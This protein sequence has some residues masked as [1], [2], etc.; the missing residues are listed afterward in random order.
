MRIVR[1]LF[2]M[3]PIVLLSPCGCN[4]FR[5][6]WWNVPK[7]DRSVPVDES[8]GEADEGLLD[9]VEKEFR[10]QPTTASQPSTAPGDRKQ[11][12]KPPPKRVTAKPSGHLARLD[13]SV[14]TPILVIND[15]VITIEE[16]LD[17]MRKELEE[18][19]Q[20]VSLRQYRETINDRARRR[21]VL[22]IDEI[23]VYGEA[24][25]EISDEMEPAIVKAIDDTERNR[26]NQEFDGRASRY[27]A[28]IDAHGLKRKEI[29]RRIR[30][31]LVV[32]QYL[33]DKFLPLVQRPNRGELQRYYAKHPDE[34]TEPLR[35]EMF[36]IDVP[37]ARFLKGATDKES[38]QLWS[39]IR[40]PRRI[41][42]RR[43]AAQHMEQARQELASGIPFDAVAKSY[44]FGPNKSKGGEWGPV[45]P[46]GLTGRWAKAADV[47]TA[48]KPGQISDVLR[49]EEGLL[50]VK[51]GKRFEK[52]IIPF[53]EAQ[54]IIEDKLVRDYQNRLETRLIL[55]LRGKATLPNAE[56]LSSFFLAIQKAAP[57]HPDD[58]PDFKLR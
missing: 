2:V 5:W 6:D 41:E 42:A 27:Q 26:I 4:D 51:A 49:T 7:K 32:E 16:V 47:L 8:G 14:E 56:A 48:L 53:T 30:R 40:G 12:S 33:R 57:K 44:S 10:S 54:P 39:K 17:P 43:A 58:K 38:E 36:L 37:Y 34:F 35:V 22:L 20:E 29:R 3:L 52:R 50:L 15:E 45:S 18:L 28:Y 13:R 19:A 46:D 24:T 9:E 23:L 55:K 11:W 21:V 31:R 25:K 1:L